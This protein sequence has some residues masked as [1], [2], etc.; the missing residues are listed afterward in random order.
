MLDRKTSL[1]FLRVVKLVV[2]EDQGIALKVLAQPG[3]RGPPTPPTLDQPNRSGSIAIGII[4]HP[5][6]PFS[7]VVYGF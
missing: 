6:C 1:N 2:V 5:S 3:H 7:C 4:S